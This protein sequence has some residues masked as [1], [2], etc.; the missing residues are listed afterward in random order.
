MSLSSPNDDQLTS[1]S[2]PGAASSVRLTSGPV[3]LAPTRW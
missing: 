2:A 3:N 1:I